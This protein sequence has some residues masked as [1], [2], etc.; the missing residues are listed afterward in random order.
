[1]SSSITIKQF[2]NENIVE[3]QDLSIVLDRV[4]VLN[5][6]SCCIPRNALTFLVGE[7]GSGKTSLVR[8]I[9]GLTPTNNGVIS[10]QNI[11]GKAPVFGYVPQKIEFPKHLQMTVGEYLQYSANVPINQIKTTLQQVDFPESHIEKRITELSGGQIQ[12]LLLAAELYRSPDILFLDEPLSNVDDASERHIIDVIMEIKNHG[13]TIVIIT[14]DWQM[15]S[16]YANHVI[17]LNQ[18]IICETSESCICRNSLSK[19]NI[20]TIQKATPD[21][22]SVHDGYCYIQN[23]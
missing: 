14:H 3:C 17:C 6:A 15:I 12:K 11:N 1:M 13:V 21:P 7:N 22:N 5:N 9:L 18:N 10:I 8:S 23:I 2:T 20:Q 4:E 16:V 19:I